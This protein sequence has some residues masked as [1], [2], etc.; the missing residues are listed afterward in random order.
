MKKY[1]KKSVVVEAM[2]FK[3]D[4]DALT[5]LQEFMQSE[6]RVSYEKTD[7]PILNVETPE[8]VKPAH[9]GDYVVKCS[10]GNY[11]PYE[12]KLFEIN[13]EAVEE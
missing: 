5:E 13:F 2:Q 6:L 10:D 9:V 8:G 7:D 3:D 11:Y 4:A 1:R 12:R